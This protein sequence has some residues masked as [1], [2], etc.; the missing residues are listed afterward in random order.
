MSERDVQDGRPYFDRIGAAADRIAV[1]GHPMIAR[2]VAAY[3]RER[4]GVLKRQPTGFGREAA[5]DVMD[6]ADG[7]ERLADR[8]EAHAS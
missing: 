1:G 7:A 6:L 2:A 3:A 4:R 8:L 5:Q